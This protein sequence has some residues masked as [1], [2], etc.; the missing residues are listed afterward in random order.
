MSNNDIK[1]NKI[2]FEILSDLSK[3]VE[4]C[5]FFANKFKELEQKNK[6]NLT[7]LS[8]ISI[9]NGEGI[10]KIFEVQKIIEKLSLLLIKQYSN[11]D[12]K[13]LIKEIEKI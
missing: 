12:Y 8:M 6:N 11:D 9:L 2:Q 4:N 3:L 10:A 7:I 1:I 13:E 5:K